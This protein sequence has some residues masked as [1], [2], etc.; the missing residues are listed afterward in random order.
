AIYKDAR[1]R[2]LKPDGRLMPS[3]LTIRLAPVTAPRTHALLSFW[4]RAD[5]GLDLTPV[6]LQAKSELQRADPD[7]LTL[8][9]APLTWQDT[10]LNQ[11][12]SPHAAGDLGFTAATTGACHGF[13]VWFDA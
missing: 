2:W 13:A 5:L 12:T 11:L 4:E 3:R 10:N 9:A 6:G 1:H 7:D 8:L